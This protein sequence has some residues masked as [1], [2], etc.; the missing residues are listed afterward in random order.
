VVESE[1]KVIY[2]NSEYSLN[3]LTKELLKIEYK[4]LPLE[5]WNFEG[6]LLQDIYNKT[7]LVEEE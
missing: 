6:R 5:F 3:S 7:Y 4:I 1:N 2:N